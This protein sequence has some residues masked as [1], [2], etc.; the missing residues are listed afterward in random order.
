[1]GS[2]RSLSNELEYL[3]RHKIYFHMYFLKDAFETF[4]LFIENFE[5]ALKIE[6]T[7]K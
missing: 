2:R 4:K 3:L 5:K 6:D 7:G 1:M